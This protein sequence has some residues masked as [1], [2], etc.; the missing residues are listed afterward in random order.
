MTINGPAIILF[1]FYVVTAEKQGVPPE[2]LD[3]LAPLRVAT[4]RLLGKH[5]LPVHHDLEYPAGGRDQLDLRLGKRLLDLGRQTGG[6]RLIV[7]DDAVLDGD[8]HA[9]PLLAGGNA[10]I[11]AVPGGDAKGARRL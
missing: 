4:Q 2:Q 11:V 3:H 7:S 6:P 1:A 8:L 9:R 10:R 5:Q